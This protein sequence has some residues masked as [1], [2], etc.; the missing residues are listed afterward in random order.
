M[1]RLLLFVGVA[2]IAAG[3]TLGAVVTT[4]DSSLDSYRGSQ[5]PPDIRVPNITLP[6]YRGSTVS[7][8]ALEGKVLVLTFL[9][10][11][12]TATCPIIAA[13]IGRTWPLLTA[14]ER[15]QVRFYAISVNPR[16]DTPASIRRFLAARHAAAA[17][18]WLVGSVR[19]MR[20]VWREFAVLP[21]ID[22]GNDDV[23]SAGLRVFD[24]RGI[25]VSFLHVGVDLTPANL[26]H[27]IRLALSART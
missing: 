14:T 26:V 7:L 23:H 6:S 20:P 2:V 24:P 5:P 13:L 25:W 17:L 12:C 16:V 27:D 9:D 8:R 3:A 11:K 10:S 1:K 18:D 21:A 15:A 19:E 22:T 4:R